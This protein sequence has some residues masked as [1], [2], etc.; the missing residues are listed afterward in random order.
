MTDCYRQLLRLVYRL[1]FVLVA[2]ARD[3]LLDTSDGTIRARYTDWYSLSR[4]TRVAEE[5]RGGP[6]AD[7][8]RQLRVVFAA[9]GS[10]TGEPALGF[11]G[12][13]SFLWSER[14]TPDLHCAELP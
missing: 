9:L 2:E 10:P 4:L 12:L 13:V 8:W 1:L 3:L 14:A 7:L 6:H 11:P 5:T